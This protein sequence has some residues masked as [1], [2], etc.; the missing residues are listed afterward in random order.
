M[1]ILTETDLIATLNAAPGVNVTRGLFKQSLR[2]LFELRGEAVQMGTGNRVT[3]VYD[4]TRVNEWQ[5]YLAVRAELIRRGEWHSKRP[6]DWQDME[7]IV[8][9]N[10]HEDVLRELFPQPQE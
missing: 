5:E 7:A 6:Y 2:P 8:Q 10:A 1:N 9:G 3:W 4:A